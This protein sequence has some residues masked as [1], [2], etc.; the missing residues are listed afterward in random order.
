MSIRWQHRPVEEVLEEARI[1]RK[2]IAEGWV[3]QPS[4][5]NQ[6]NLDRRILNFTSAIRHRGFS[7]ADALLRPDSDRAFWHGL[8]QMPRKPKG[9][10]VGHTNYL[11]LGEELKGN[12]NYDQNTGALAGKVRMSEVF[13]LDKYVEADKEAAYT[14]ML[15]RIPVRRM[16][17]EMVS[18]LDQAGGIIEDLQGKLEEAQT[19]NAS[20]TNKIVGMQLELDGVAEDKL[21]MQ[22][23]INHLEGQLLD[24]QQKTAPSSLSWLDRVR[25]ARV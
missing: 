17:E 22:G 3:Y 18:F 9:T 14:A 2:A 23:R 10:R 7:V 20:L 19:T 6:T 16:V 12:P 21:A 13:D 11:T 5:I 1:A 15:Q 4:K 8:F 24:L 25:G